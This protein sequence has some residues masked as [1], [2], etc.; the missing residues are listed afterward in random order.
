MDESDVFPVE[1]ADVAMQAIADGVARITMTR[2]E[3]LNIARNDIKQSREMFHHLMDNGFVKNPPDGML[4]EAL[5][6]A[7]SQ[8]KK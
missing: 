8:V 4:D 5:Q 3:A 2:D 1:S 6:Y 7:I